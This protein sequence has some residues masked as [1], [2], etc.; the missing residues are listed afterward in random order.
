LQAV[1]GNNQNQITI[2]DTQGK[3]WLPIFTG[4][5][6]CFVRENS[7]FIKAIRENFTTLKP[8]ESGRIETGKKL[9]LLL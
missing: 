7:H 6:N 8:L 2:A 4:N 5:G 9:T 1:T 3:P